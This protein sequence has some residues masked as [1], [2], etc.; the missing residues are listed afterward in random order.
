MDWPLIRMIGRRV[1]SGYPASALV[2]SDYCHAPDWS[3]QNVIIKVHCFSR[4]YQ[5]AGIQIW[6][7]LEWIFVARAGLDTFALLQFPATTPPL[8]RWS[9]FNIFYFKYSI[10]KKWGEAV[11]MRH[12]FLASNYMEKWEWTIRAWIGMSILDQQNITEHC[13][14]FVLLYRL[15]CTLYF[16]PAHVGNNMRC[17]F[18]IGFKFSTERKF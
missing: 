9:L 12:C 11:F 1:I 3:F 6:I 5:S 2:T 14:T 8:C 15:H 16:M 13:R 17:L 18:C 10:E 7:L 4:L